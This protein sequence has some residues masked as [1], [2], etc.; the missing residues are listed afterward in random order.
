MLVV[1]TD[2]ISDPWDPS[3]HSRVAQWT[4]DYEM[5][6]EVPL[7]HLESAAEEHVASS[8]L[9]TLNWALTDWLV[10]ERVDVRAALAKFNLLTRTAPR[11]TGLEPF[12]CPN[13]QLGLLIGMPAVG[14]VLGASVAPAPLPLTGTLNQ[15]FQPNRSAETQSSPGSA[16]RSASKPSTTKAASPTG[17]DTE[18]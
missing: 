6:I 18:V 10:A 7:E 1:V 3:I 13:G 4:F 11:V 2:G 8:W 16:C 14:E 15:N 9:P 12:V 17:K 5:A